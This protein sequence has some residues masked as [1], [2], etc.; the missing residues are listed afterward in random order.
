MIQNCATLLT[1]HSMK[2][3]T[4]S[5]FDQQNTIAE[6]QH[7]HPKQADLLLYPHFLAPAQADH[8][9]NQLLHDTPWQQ[10]EIRVFGKTHK[11]PRLQHFQG[12][13]GIRYQYSDLILNSQPWHPQVNAI[14]AFIYELTN[15]RF[16]SV[17]LNQYRHGNDKMGWH[18]DDEPELGP[19]PVIASVTLGTARKFVLKHKYDTDIAKVELVL[20]HG[21]LLIMQGTTQHFWQHAVPASRRIF[22]PR[23]NLTFRSVIN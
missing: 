11:I 16:N 7:I 15:Y 18:S 5:L 6:P 14:K 20:P 8:Y 22:T 23:I 9:L 3:T 21:S 12:D 13:A 19:N 10:D 2:P 1:G 17:L 4:P